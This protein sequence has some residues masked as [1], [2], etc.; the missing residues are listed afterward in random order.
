MGEETFRK[1]FMPQEGIPFFVWFIDFRYRVALFQKEFLDPL[2]AIKT[3]VEPV[4]ASSSWTSYCT[5]Q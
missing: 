3:G 1:E 2:E 4:S 5:I